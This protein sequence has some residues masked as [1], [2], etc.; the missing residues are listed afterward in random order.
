MLIREYLAPSLVVGVVVQNPIFVSRCGG[1]LAAQ[2]PTLDGLLRLAHR[3][4]D[5]V[6]PDPY[7]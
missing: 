5:V 2:G 3:E 1:R 7:I 6:F 4:S